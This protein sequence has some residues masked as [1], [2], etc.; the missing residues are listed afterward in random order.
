MKPRTRRSGGRGSARWA[1][2]AGLLLTTVAALPSL[3]E[4]PCGLP[5]FDAR[6][7]T[8][9]PGA[10]LFIGRVV[11][12]AV[13]IEGGWAVSVEV[14]DPIHLPTRRREYDLVL[15]ER[16]D[17]EASV[18]EATRFERTALI[19]TWRSG[20]PVK[21][22]AWQTEEGHLVADTK[23]GVVLMNDERDRIRRH[24]VRDEVDLAAA[25]LSLDRE[26]E[27]MDKIGVL[28]EIGR[29]VADSERY[30]RIVSGQVKEKRLRRQLASIHRKAHAQ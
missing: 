3:G 13:P 1:V 5:E 14:L 11:V 16:R 26:A 19:E 8:F 18:C 6:P 25:L 21:V 2:V 12:P 4:S 27:S 29:F 30:R 22:L 7:D 28:T 15:V 20:D 17:P 24:V 23:S 10:F 9:L